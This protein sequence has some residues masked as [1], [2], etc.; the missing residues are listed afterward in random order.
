MKKIEM[1]LETEKNKARRC[2]NLKAYRDKVKKY[3][4]TS[5]EDTVGNIVYLTEI[6]NIQIKAFTY[7]RHQGAVVITVKDMSNGVELSEAIYF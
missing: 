3:M 2:K 4:K 1:I 7:S 6:N 5:Y